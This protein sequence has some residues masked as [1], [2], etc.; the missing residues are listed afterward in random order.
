MAHSNR[1]K[2]REAR[3]GLTRNQ[4]RKNKQSGNAGN[5]SSRL[6]DTIKWMEQN[7]EKKRQ[8]DTPTAKT[9]KVVTFSRSKRAIIRRAGALNRLETSLLNN[10]ELKDEDVTRIKKEIQVL[11]NRI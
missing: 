6:A 4:L 1:K 7:A 11:K 10:K 5:Q 9:V 3:G 8:G 2:L